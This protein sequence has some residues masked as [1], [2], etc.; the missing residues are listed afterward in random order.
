[1][2][3]RVSR[4]EFLGRSALAGT[5]IGLGVWSNRSLAASKSPNEKLN[6]VMIGTA[7]QPLFSVNNVKQENIV[8]MC[9]IDDKY[10]GVAQ[11]DFPR[12][13]TYNDFRKM[14]DQSDIDTVVV[15][16]PCPIH[17]HA[18]AAALHRGKHV[19]CE[20]PLTHTIAET[21]AI[22]KLAAE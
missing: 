12:A 3:N 16:A 1:M 10:L 7:S 2:S 14:L 19:Y 21:R 17:T 20:K 15:A 11:R 13:K 5:A 9:D 4:R 6:I 8:A 22:A 18:T